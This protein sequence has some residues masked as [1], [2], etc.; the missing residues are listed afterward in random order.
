MKNRAVA[1]GFAVIFVLGMAGCSR[2]GMNAGEKL[3]ALMLFDSTGKKVGIHEYILPGKTLLLHF[4]GAACCLTYSKP[5]FRAVSEIHK[6]KL[7]MDVTVVSVNLDYSPEIVAEITKDLDVRHP[8]LNDK[9]SGFFRTEPSLKNVFP[10]ALILVVDDSGI[11]RGKMMGPQL[12][13]AIKD[14]INLARKTKLG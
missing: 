2:I 1:W 6:S 8:V 9:D 13:P 3:P 12:Q 7:Y 10:L 11:I 14:L 5:T 4:W